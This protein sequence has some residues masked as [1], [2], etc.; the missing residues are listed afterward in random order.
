MGLFARRT[1]SNH[2]NDN[3]NNKI[4]AL[5]CRLQDVLDMPVLVRTMYPAGNRSLDPSTSPSCLVTIHPYSAGGQRRLVLNPYSPLI[6][7]LITTQD[8]NCWSCVC[9]L[10]Q[11]MVTSCT[12]PTPLDAIACGRISWPMAKGLICGPHW[13][14]LGPVTHEDCNFFD[15]NNSSSS[16]VWH[17][18]GIAIWPRKIHHVLVRHDKPSADKVV[19]RVGE[20]WERRDQ[21]LYQE[22]KALLQVQKNNSNHHTSSKS[23]KQQQSNKPCLLLGDNP[24][25][26]ITYAPALP[27]LLLAQSIQQP[28]NSNDSINTGRLRDCHP[29]EALSI[30]TMILLSVDKLFCLSLFFGVPLIDRTRTWK[31]SVKTRLV[32]PPPPTQTEIDTYQASLGQQHNQSPQSALQETLLR[33]ARQ[34]WSLQQPLIV[35]WSGGIDSTAVLVALLQTRPNNNNT[36]SISI[37]HDD[38]SIQENPSFYAQHIQGKLSCILRHNKT[39][40]ELAQLYADSQASI[41]VTGELG[42]QLFGSDRCRAAFD[43]ARVD[44]QLTPDERACCGGDPVVVLP[45][46]QTPWAQALWPVLQERGLLGST[47]GWDE[48]IRPQLEQSP[49]PIVTLYDFLWWLNYSAKWQTVALRC[50]HDGGDYYYDNQ[51]NVNINTNNN[52]MTGAIHHFYQDRDLECWACIPEN[53]ATKFPNLQDWKTYKQP[54]K[55]FIYQFHDD[56]EYRQHKCKMG[57]LTFELPHM[58]Q[59]RVERILGLVPLANGS[60]VRLS[61]GETSLLHLSQE[62]LQRWKKK[63]NNK[64]DGASSIESVDELLEDWIL[65]CT[66][67]QPPMNIPTEHVDP[68]GS[69]AAAAAFEAAP[70]F[71][72]TDERQ[73][74]IANP[75]TQTTLVAKCSALLPPTLVQGKR[76]LDLGACLGAMCHWC[77]FHGARQVVGVEPQANFCERMQQLL[78]DAAPTWPATGS[79]G[80]EE[81]RFRVVCAKAKEFLQSCPDESFDV[82]VVAGVLHCF[83]DPIAVLTEMAR[84]A[85]CIVIESVHTTYHTLGFQRSI[86]SPISTCTGLLELAPSAAVNKAGGDV[87]FTGLAVVPSESL[88]RNMLS[89][90][91]YN[92]IT[93]VTM[94]GHPTKPDD[95][96]T[97]TGNRRYQASPLRYFLRCVRP[98]KTIVR[99][100]SLEECVTTG[101]GNERKW[102]SARVGGRHWTKYDHVEFVKDEAAHDKSDS[103]VENGD[104]PLSSSLSAADPGLTEKT[105]GSWAFDESVARRFRNEAKSHIPDYVNVVQ[106]CLECIA[107]HFGRKSLKHLHAV[108]VGCAIGYTMIELLKF[109]VGNV[110]GYDTSASMLKVA[111]QNL[112]E[113]T[114]QS[115]GTWAKDS[116]HLFL[117]EVST[118]VPPKPPSRFDKGDLDVVVINWTLH[119]IVEEQNRRNYLCQI[120]ETLKPGGIL[121]LTEKTQQDDVTREL[122]YDWKEAPPQNVPRDVIDAKRSKLKGVLETLSVRWYLGTLEACGFENV[123]VLRAKFA[124]VTFLCYK[125]HSMMS[126]KVIDSKPFVK[127]SNL[128][129]NAADVHYDGSSDPEPF[130]LSAWSNETAQASVEE[131]D[132]T[133]ST[134]GY[135][136]SGEATLTRSLKS[137]RTIGTPLVSGMYFACHGKFQLTGGSGFIASSPASRV[138]PLFTVGGP[139]EDEGDGSLLGMLPYIDG[140]TDSLL[141]GPVVMGSP[142]LNHLHF[143]NNIKQ[144]QHTHP[145]A[146]AGMVIHGSGVCRVV[147]PVSGDVTLIQLETGMVFCIPRNSPHAFETEENE[148][149][150]VIAFHPDSDFGPTPTNHPMVNRTIVNGVSASL[151]P[152]IQTKS[153]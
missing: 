134:F 54:L 31:S 38:E 79:N 2:H 15:V 55:E 61:S 120:Y 108:D 34:L 82:I 101:V 68:W 9:R 84:V 105:P 12:W 138:A 152:S 142:C 73:R 83:Q 28:S 72:D 133:R 21:V 125:P 81:E 22:W 113:A 53:H 130:V 32:V 23:K 48:W 49:I 98:A 137:G 8:D 57:S 46:L 37:L 148:K 45:P 87:S 126:D 127:W 143:P 65:N 140:C 118:K 66:T 71:A 24:L 112:D 86:E 14:L 149:L 47:T 67:S 26:F 100:R 85:P 1:R 104:Q 128:E 153:V 95:V 25:Q 29:A 52:N 94:Q 77:L 151:L 129:K 145:S 58:Q 69:S 44:D 62:E 50:L 116:Y 43:S 18:P 13:N 97:Y 16:S 33:R 99:M 107:K 93:R 51:V 63:T 144:T 64:D 111:E 90:I 3:D 36:R 30:A 139:L 70:Q 35:C 27:I 110:Y 141:I 92:A 5:A 78:T 102:G 136:Y 60:V 76:V 56:N 122:Y 124:F 39:L 42:D 114:Q 88:V 59:N 20:R 11:C 123:T 106:T 4:H 75:V 146:R 89:A 10:A 109:G 132:S 40:S 91:G 121:L 7:E 119:F 115:N 150:D 131:T 41:L 117:A 135:V 103:V 147:D 74:R 96:L 80:S 6:L 17:P 19:T